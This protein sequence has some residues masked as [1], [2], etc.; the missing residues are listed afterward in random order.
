MKTYKTLEI[1]RPFERNGQ[2]PIDKTSVFFSYESA[3]KYAH[4]DTT[5]YPGQIISV[6]DEQHRKTAI[7][8]LDYD[9]DSHYRLVLKSI[10]VGTQTTG[11]FN[12]LG[13]VDTVEDLPEVADNGEMYL[14]RDDNTFYV[15]I[16]VNEDNINWNPLS[17][18][19][20]LVTETKDGLFRHDVYTTLINNSTNGS[21]YYSSGDGIPENN[22]WIEVETTTVEKE[23][24]NFALLSVGR[25]KQ[26]VSSMTDNAKPHVEISSP[27]PKDN[28]VLSQIRPELN[29]V[30]YPE[31]G[32]S[33][34][35]ITVIEEV[36]DTT[37][38]DT[39]PESRDL[40]YDEESNSY[41]YHCFADY[42]YSEVRRTYVYRVTVE[43]NQS[44]DGNVTAGSCE[45]TIRFNFYKPSSASTN[46]ESL[47]VYTYDGDNIIE[48]E[49][50][51]EKFTNTP[52]DTISLYLPESHYLDKVTFVNQ[53]D[54]YARSLFTGPETIANQKRYR[55]HV[56]I[57]FKSPGKFIFY[58]SENALSAEQ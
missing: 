41:A 9:E 45:N 42:I 31:M 55:Y 17:L 43:Y 46:N 18:N 7:Y 30:Y 50:H 2:F 54:L 5:A 44:D 22:K 3:V 32:G 35:R 33:I 34:K 27:T 28:Y 51:P 11:G 24:D 20:D 40:V 14:V 6:V 13:I 15:A 1:L 39:I 56:P 49:Y 58:I 47:T 29:I 38:L 36:T 10:S 37:I 53:N 26:I 52:T 25:V 12:L 19:I 8:K 16:E 23:R 48:F 21:V 4:E 57:G